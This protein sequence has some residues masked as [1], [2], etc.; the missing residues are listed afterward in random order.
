MPLTLGVPKEVKVREKRVALTP[1]GAGQLAGKGISVFIQRGAG[2]ASGFSDTAYEAAGAVLVPDAAALYGQAR[3][4]VKVKEPQPSEFGLLR[5][6]HL[7]FCYLHLASPENH[8]LLQA[9]LK[10]GVTAAAFETVEKDGRRPLLKPMSEIAG[11]LAAAYGT[12]LV[13]LLGKMTGSLKLPSD[14][15]ASLER[16]ASLYPEPPAGG[17]SPYALIW[18]GGVAGEKA[19]EFCLKMG[20]KA[21]LVENNPGRREELSAKFS[22]KSAAFFSPENLPAEVLEASELLIGCVHQA[23]ARALR[24]LSESSLERSSKSIKKVMV[25]ISI[26]QG[27][28]FPQSEPRTYDDPVYLDTFGNLRFTVTNMPSLCGPAASKALEAAILP[29]AAA[30]ALDAERAFKEDP[31]LRLAVNVQAGNIVNEAVRRAHHE[32]H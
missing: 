28:N 6:D 18:G 15:H 7:L 13:P 2:Q 21:A 14:F 19:L 30:L 26:D 10:S 11:G 27:G 17:V 5:T 32:D 3:L 20:A 29:Y 23:G 9:L 16:I 25:D 4:I 8:P 1:E 12:Y 31:G 22:Q 24:V